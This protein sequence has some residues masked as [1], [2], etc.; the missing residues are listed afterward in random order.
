MDDEVTLKDIILTA[1]DYWHEMWRY[2]YLV[3]LFC[4]PT[5]SWYMYK[6]FTH[7]VTYTAKMKFIVEGGGGASSMIGNLLGQFGFGNTEKGFGPLKIKEVMYSTVNM[8]TV[9][10]DTTDNQPMLAN[11]LIKLYDLNKKWT[12]DEQNW[13]NFKFRHFTIETLDSLEIRALMRLHAATVGSESNPKPWMGY[14][15]DE[16]TGIMSLSIKLGDEGLA[17]RFLQSIYDRTREFFEV[18]IFEEQM[19]ANALLKAKKD[20]LEAY[21]EQNDYAMAKYNQTNRGLIDETY[22]VPLKKLQRQNTV[23]TLAL[24][25]VMKNY[26]LSDFTLKSL[27]PYF[28]T[29]DKPVGPL[30]PAMSSILVRFI[31]GCIFGGMLF[32]TFIIGRKILRDTLNE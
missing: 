19:K 27:K 11:E 25:E 18:K 20:S 32:I 13:E 31:I 9:L 26:E 15:V 30:A 24:G 22:M 5:V 7:E 16:D 28:F 8:S 12:T 4:I 21:I 1:K 23:A 14:A 17:K 2:W 29:L 6:H 10:L 3:P